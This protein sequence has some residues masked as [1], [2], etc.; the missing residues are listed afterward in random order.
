MA[1]LDKQDKHTIS[2]LGRLADDPDTIRQL[3]R[4]IKALP[5]EG[6]RALDAYIEGKKKTIQKLK[7]LN[8]SFDDYRSYNGHRKNQ[9]IPQPARAA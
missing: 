3:L 1:P 4:E 2:V 7:A 9:H 8:A 5:P 6:V